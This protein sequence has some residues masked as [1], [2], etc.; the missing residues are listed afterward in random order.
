MSAQKLRCILLIAAMLYLPACLAGVLSK[1]DLIARFPSP[2]IV[3]D[4]DAE[5]PVWPIFKQ[6]ATE[7]EL[8]GYVFETID[9][10]PIP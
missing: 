8:V 2:Y 6:N 7:N 5:M 9:L 4:Q 10:A 1:A 3:A